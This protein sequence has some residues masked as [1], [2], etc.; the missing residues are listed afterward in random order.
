MKFQGHLPRHQSRHAAPRPGHAVWIAI[1][2]L[3]APPM[4]HAQVTALWTNIDGTCFFGGCAGDRSGAPLVRVNG[5]RIAVGIP[6]NDEGAVVDS[7]RVNYVDRAGRTAE[8][9]GFSSLIFT[10]VSPGEFGAALAAF[11]DA[12]LLA[13]GPATSLGRGVVYLLT[14]NMPN[15]LLQVLG[16]W[17]NPAG[18][19]GSNTFFGR[20]LAALPG[21][22]FA[23]SSLSSNVTSLDRGKVFIYD[24]ATVSPPLTVIS[25]TAPTF[26]GFARALAPLGADRLLIGDTGNRFGSTPTASVLIHDFSGTRLRTILDPGARILENFGA[27]IVPYL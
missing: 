1:A 27:V 9:T 23:A 19:A 11:P 15:S 8:G 10:G 2:L 12:R 7:G 24:A 16:T 26:D 18:T 20:S 21:N 14:T 25:N 4:T 6:R 3:L 17:N 5:G 22:R 13:S